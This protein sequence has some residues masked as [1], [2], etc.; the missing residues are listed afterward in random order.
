MGIAVALTA[1]FF[2]AL[3]ARFY[4]HSTAQWSVLLLNLTKNLIAVTM[5]AILLWV[6]PMNSTATL[7]TAL[8]LL[9]SGIIGIGLGDTALFAA[10]KR[11][12]EQN[13]LLIAETGAPLIVVTLG[14]FLL[15]ETL[16]WQHYLGMFLVLLATDL[17]IGWRRQ[18]RLDMVAVALAGVAALCQATGALISRYFLTTTD[19]GVLESAV[20]RLLGGLL[21]AT[22]GL[23]VMRARNVPIRYQLLTPRQTSKLLVAILLGTIIGVFMLQWSLDLLPAGLAQT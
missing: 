20:W 2:W 14:F 12:G 17:A 1:A 16:S 6:L 8:I 9:L 3:S 22:V 5:L 10:L 19:L 13:T 21:F 23:A 4:G 11:M 15:A 18:N 7:S